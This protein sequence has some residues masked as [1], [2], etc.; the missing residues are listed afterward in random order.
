MCVAAKR[1]DEFVRFSIIYIYITCYAKNFIEFMRSQKLCS[2]P[3]NPTKTTSKNIMHMVRVPS[4]WARGISPSIPGE[5]PV[6]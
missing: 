5:R 4:L 1:C 3:Q 2:G 6:V